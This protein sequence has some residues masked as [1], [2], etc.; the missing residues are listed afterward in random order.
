[1]LD[2]QLYLIFLNE[3]SICILCVWNEV[4]RTYFHYFASLKFLY[5]KVFCIGHLFSNK[6]VFYDILL[7]IKLC[8]TL[9]FFLSK[10]IPLP[11]ELPQPCNVR[12]LVE[13]YWDIQGVPKR[14]FFELLSH[15]TDSE[16][17]KEK[18][19]EFTTPEGQVSYLMLWLTCDFYQ[20]ISWND[21]CFSSL[22]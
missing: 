8:E 9:Y 17:E 19:K 2:T 10:D 4:S 6:Y 13:N 15:L 3:Y 18:L 22:S 7:K 1:M 14:Y 21:C 20:K 5:H 16:L 12:Y 11:K